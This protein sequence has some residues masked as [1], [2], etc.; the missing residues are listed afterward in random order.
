MLTGK[1]TRLLRQFSKTEIRIAKTVAVDNFLG[2]SCELN[3]R[4]LYAKEEELLPVTLHQFY[5]SNPRVLK[6]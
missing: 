5:Y 1:Q 4:G 2:L 6:V 3:S